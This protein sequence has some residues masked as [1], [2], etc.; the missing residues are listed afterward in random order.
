MKNIKYFAPLC[1]IVVLLGACSQDSKDNKSVM[2]TIDKGSATAPE[3]SSVN[4]QDK[5]LVR[6][7]HAIPGAAAV[8]TFAGDTK[9]FPEVSYKTVTPYKE[10]ADDRQA[11][12]VRPVGEDASQPLAENSESLS[13]GKHYTLIAMPASSKGELTLHVFNDDLVQPH[14]GKARV[15]VINVAAGAGEVDVYTKLDQQPLFSGVNFDTEAEYKEVDPM[16]TSLE[17]R[18]EEK[19]YARITIP[20]HFEAEKT[21]TIVVLG[22][23]SK[24]DTMT[25]EDQLNPSYADLANT[26]AI[27]NVPL[28]FLAGRMVP[29][30]PWSRSPA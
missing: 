5:A 11:F 15:R 21:Y 18:P 24:L 2:T 27:N 20:V 4:Q 26:N 6:V 29:H 23:A 7:I 19:G 9:V 10:L 25:V 17:I 3:A 28:G 1:G 16:S 14:P 8:D 13:G 22:Q 12:K 30:P